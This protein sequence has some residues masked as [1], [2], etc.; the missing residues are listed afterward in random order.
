M[1]RERVV[2]SVVYLL[3][4]RVVLQS[5]SIVSTLLIARW[6][7]PED[8]GLMALAAIFM[9]A[10]MLLSELGIG[11]AIIQFKDVAEEELNTA[12]WFT[13]G[14]AGVAYAVLYVVA[15]LVAQF[16]A[17]PKLTVV[18]RVV[19]VAAVFTVLQKVPENLLRKQVHLDQLS[20]VEVISIAAGIPLAL[21]LAWGGAG[22]WALVA[23]S[24]STSVVR[25]VLIFAFAGWRP[26]LRT[27]SRRV[28]QLVTFSGAALGSRLLW[29]V[30]SHSD[31][32]VLGRV[33][34]DVALGFYAMGSQIALIPL[35]KVTVI[36]NEVAAPVLAEL[37]GDLAAMRDC[38]L[39]SVRIVGWITL[40]MCV[41]MLL[42]AEDTI[43]LV[44][45]DKWLPAAPVVQ[46]LCVYA[47]I[48]SL[49]ALF[50]PVLMASYRATSMVRYNLALTALMPLGFWAGAWWAGPRGVAMVWLTL[51]PIAAAVMVAETLRH[52]Q[53]PWRV[54]WLDLWR[55]VAATAV[56]A[57]A[58][59]TVDW[60]ISGGG[61]G[62][63]AVVV[64]TGVIVYGAAL[65]L[66]GDAVLHDFGVIFGWLRDRAARNWPSAPTAG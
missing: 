27:G 65:W 19:G 23:G 32:A 34:G 53:M 35:D 37:Q 12:F 25:C 40:P 56:M 52:L 4:S 2:R 47:A 48:R 64:F 58:T 21:G 43:R 8:Y 15:P 45:T 60:G 11:A 44:L 51:Y 39:R 14:T 38:L 66:G 61:P 13:L 59:L 55:S 22:V 7:N 29:T 9:A 50:P 33:A 49:T 20:I 6:L 24:A 63:L 1:I 3:V 42:V 54:L 36:V 17:S 18:L 30:Y 57:L 10:F 31:H 5:L 26:G 46:L 62:R 41:G 16:F 28:R